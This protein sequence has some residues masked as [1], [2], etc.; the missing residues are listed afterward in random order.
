MPSSLRAAKLAGSLTESEL[1]RSPG[2]P[3]LARLRRGPCAV[4]ECVEEI[5]CNPCEPACPHGAIKVGEPITNLPALDPE[6]CTGCGLCI[7]ACPGLAIFLIDLSRS[8]GMAAVSLPY[9]WLPVPRVGDDVL[10]LD[11]DGTPCGSGKVI[12]AVNPRRN[13]RTPVVTV[14]VQPELAGKVRGLRPAG[15]VNGND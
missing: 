10:V 14:T 2:Y 12:R 4:I 5:P 11:R 3:P 9:E 6:L 15:E 13:D 1:G 8:D 7:A